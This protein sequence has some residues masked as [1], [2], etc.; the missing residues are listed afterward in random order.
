MVRLGGAKVVPFL[1]FLAFSAPSYAQSAGRAR[2]AD[3]SV[4]EFGTFLKYAKVYE[5]AQRKRE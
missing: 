3:L 2:W 4:E 5:A 1:V